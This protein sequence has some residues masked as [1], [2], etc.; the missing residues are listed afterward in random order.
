MFLQQAE[1]EPIVGERSET[2]E[3]NFESDANGG[4]KMIVDSTSPEPGNTEMYV[5]FIITLML[6][7]LYIGRYTWT[8]VIKLELHSWFY[9]CLV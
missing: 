4:S 2:V 5:N 3:V 9:K 6:T 7:I 8:I 1:N